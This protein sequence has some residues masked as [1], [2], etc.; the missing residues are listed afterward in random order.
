M[1][2]ERELPVDVPVQLGRAWQR[3][4]EG[5]DRVQALLAFEWATLSAL[6]VALRNG[7][8]FVAHSFAFR[9][10]A[11]LLI[12]DAVWK[13]QRNHTR[14]MNKVSTNSYHKPCSYEDYADHYE[15]K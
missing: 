9:S 11:T 3:V 1:C 4:I 13:A 10:Q 8:V 5:D 12:P 14:G 2:G 6:R 7:S 15:L